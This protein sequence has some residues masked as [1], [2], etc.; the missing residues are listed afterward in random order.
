MKRAREIGII[1]LGKFGLQLGGTLRSLGITAIGVDRDPARVQRARDVASQAYEAD[2]TDRTAL[3][4]LKFSS[5]ETVVV[6][7]GGLL[8]TSILTL[9]NLQELGVK[10]IIIKAGSPMHKKVLER[11]GA[12]RVIQPEIEAATQLA[13]SLDS[14]GLLDLLPIG[15]GVVIQ[16]AEV[17]AWAGKSLRALNLRYASHVLVAAVREAGGEYRFV[18]DPDRALGAGDHL[19]IIGYQDAV[20]AVRGRT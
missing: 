15:R 5:L 6:A 4:Q 19:L 9:L 2:A 14:P 7:V 20:A 8:E 18:P 11:L 10:N 12:S 13:L 16:E 17:G 3:A 1:G